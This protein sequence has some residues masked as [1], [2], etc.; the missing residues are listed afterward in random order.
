MK[1]PL[2]QA[3]AKGM[4]MSDEVWAR[5]ANPWSVW[6]R[7]TAAPLLVASIWSRVWLGVWAWAPIA[8]SILWIWLNPRLFPKPTST[9]NWASKAVLGERVWL[10]RHQVTIPERHR[11]AP[12]L[13]SG[14]AGMGALLLIPGL[15]TLDVWLTL[16]GLLLVY[17]GKVWFLDRMVWLFE[18][19][20]E[21]NQEYRSWL[22]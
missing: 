6:T 9:K 12:N 13:L 14:I 7:F 15:W 3:L 10:N 1:L 2:E 21:A 17:A 11:V 8:V 19:M 20:K 22:Y 18:D 4:A 5:H 16:V